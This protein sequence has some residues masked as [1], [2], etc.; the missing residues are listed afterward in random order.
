MTG[1]VWDGHGVPLPKNFQTREYKE[2]FKRKELL[3]I[4]NN[5]LLF[6]QRLVIHRNHLGIEGTKSIMRAYYLW[7][8][9]EIELEAFFSQLCAESKNERISTAKMGLRLEYSFTTYG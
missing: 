9:I 6:G 3:M 2:H 4:Q 8:R 5:C 7:P 1:L